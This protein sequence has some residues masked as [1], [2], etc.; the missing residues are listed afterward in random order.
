MKLML[1]LVKPR[2][3]SNFSCRVHLACQRSFV[4]KYDILRFTA[5]V[6]FHLPDD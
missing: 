3:E 1:Q 4:I 2:I 6:L 5:R